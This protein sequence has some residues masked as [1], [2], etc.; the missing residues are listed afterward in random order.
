VAVL[1]SF[2]RSY[3]ITSG[4][5]ANAAATVSQS[6]VNLELGQFP[7]HHRPF[8]SFPEQHQPWNSRWQFGITIRPASVSACTHAVYTC[9][10]VRPTRSGL[11]ATPEEATGE[12][13]VTVW[14]ANGNRTLLNPHSAIWAAMSSRCR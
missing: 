12:P 11:A 6:F 2:F 3:P 9:Q 14:S 13:Q 8:P 4:L 7:F 5:L 10:G 1:G